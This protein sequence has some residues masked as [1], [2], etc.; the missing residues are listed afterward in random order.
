MHAFYIPIGL[1]FTLPPLPSL[2]TT[3]I[4]VKKT[5]NYYNRLGNLADLR[6]RAL[7]ALFLLRLINTHNRRCTPPLARR[8]IHCIY[9]QCSREIP[10][11]DPRTK[12]AALDMDRRLSR[13]VCSYGSSRVFSQFKS[14]LYGWTSF[15]RN[16]S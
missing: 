14:F 16:P 8:M 2:N 5:E 4:T 3:V 9:R 6:A 1:M 12:N 10:V 11:W 7:C 15:L 13:Q